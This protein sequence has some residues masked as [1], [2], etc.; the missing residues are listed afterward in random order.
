MRWSLGRKIAAGFALSVVAFVVVGL[1]SFR[2]VQD[3][4]STAQ[5]VSHTHEIMTR[6]ES[7]RSRIVEITSDAR[8]YALTGDARFLDRHRDAVREVDEDTKE[9]RRLTADT[10]RQQRRLDSLERLV[11]QRIAT[12]QEIV[13][14]RRATGV[15]AAGRVVAS[16][17]VVNLL[18][19]IRAVLKEFEHE[20][21]ELLRSRLADAE[22]SVRA[23][24][25]VILGGS[26]LGGVVVTL[27]AFLLTRA[28]TG[29]IRHAVT[30]LATTTQQTLVATTQQA[31]G[32]AE[33]ATA[34][35]ETTATVE[36]LRQTVQM[37]A[38]KMRT[39]AED[40]EKT[41][42]LSQSG[43]R[44]VAKTVEGMQDLKS[45]MEALAERIVTLSEQGQMISEIIAT[46][47]DLAD[48]SNLLAVNA[49]IEAAKAGEAGKGFAVVAVEVKSLSEQSKQAA[50][51]VRGILN[52]I[53][54]ATQSTVL[55]AEQA[56]KTAETGAALAS[57]AGQAVQGL[58][59]SIAGAAQSAH[60]VLVATQ[61]QTVG[62]DQ[63]ATA[64]RDIQRSSSQTMMATRQLER[65][66]QDLNTVAHRLKA[67][68]EGENGRSRTSVGALSPPAPEPVG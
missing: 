38:Q 36:E 61:Q 48:Q 9:L 23:A 34:I 1:I 21:G 55:A 52:D 65:A 11:A 30:T 6:A 68:V 64:M 46:V 62:M 24:K 66:S 63:I 37:T 42:Q 47:T 49:A 57:E 32:V 22:S 27:V 50:G 53:Q 41:G 4:I 58:T 18:T 60:Q 8:G 13:A 25:S 59:D 29:Q 26:L 45:R 16:D 56:T 51:Q 44:S 20:E 15:E 5:R 14:A 40:A 28:I 33:E 3:L 2:T 19:Q 39:V 7:L 67:F 17:R 35:Q 43:L 10:P 12:S 54:R 31:A